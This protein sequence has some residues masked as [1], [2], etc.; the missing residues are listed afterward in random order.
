MST[1][2]RISRFNGSIFFMSRAK[3]TRAFSRRHMGAH[4]RVGQAEGTEKNCTG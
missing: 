2:E 1:L 3:Y 4:V